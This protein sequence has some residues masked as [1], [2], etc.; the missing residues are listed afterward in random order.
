MTLPPNNPALLPAVLDMLPVGVR[1]TDRSGRRVFANAAS[2][3]LTAHDPAVEVHS[4]RFVLGGEALVLTTSI[5]VGKHKKLAEELF[6]RAYMD[7]LTG[8]PNRTLC[9]QSA[10]ELIQTLPPGERLALAFIDLDNFKYI[11]DF[12]SHAAGDAALVK[13]AERISR[14]L[15][16][17]DLLARLGGDEFVLLLTPVADDADLRARLGEVSEELKRPIYV[18]GY[19]IFIS[20]SMG[21]SIYPD[22]ADTYDALRRCADSAMYRVKDGIKGAVAMFDESM[23][24][25]ATGR[26]AVEQRFRLAVRDRRFC[27][28]YQPKVDIRTQEVVGVEVLLRWRDEEGAIQPP[29]SFVA[30]AIELGLIN[31][32]TRLMLAEI[33]ASMDVIGSLWGENISISINIAAKQAEDVAFMDGFAEALRATGCA[34]RFML[35]LTEEAFFTKSRFQSSILPKLRAIGTKVS[36]DDFGAGYSSLSAL[37]DIEADEIKIDRAFITDIHRR[38]R[39]QIVLKGIESLGRALGMSIIAEGIETFEELVWLQASTSIHCA[40]GYYFSRPVVLPDDPAT[41]LDHA[42]RPATAV[43]WPAP[44][45][46]NLLR[47]G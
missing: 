24:Q 25:A 31:E 40:Q 27:C 32:I 5:N 3:R 10:L 19:E 46:Q 29:G 41:A 38:P 45:R 15:R 47:A 9:E 11:N 21:A 26:M 12:Y 2:D 33:V 44:A 1:V 17:S 4:E 23:R 8:L 20:A 42:S 13:V 37:A 18:D 16:P 43:R 30:L 34:D 7:E 28:A 14:L 22:H 36:I 39:N 6:E 35:E